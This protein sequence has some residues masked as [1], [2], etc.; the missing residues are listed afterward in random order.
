MDTFADVVRTLGDRDIAQALGLRQPTVERW[1]HRDSIPPEYWI[2]LIQ[3]A[4]A[5]DVEISAHRLAVL[6]HQKRTQ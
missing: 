2:D 4:Q 5:R 6:A 3:H 1:R